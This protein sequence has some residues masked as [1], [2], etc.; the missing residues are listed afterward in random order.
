MSNPIRVCLRILAVASVLF[1]P[2]AAS[3]EPPPC[4]TWFPDFS[5]CGRSGRW[6]G[7]TMPIAAPYLFEDPFITTGVQAVGI[8]H[9][10]TD[11][12][13]GGEAWVLAVQARIAITDKLAFI[14]TKDG[15][16]WMD[17]TALGS[18]DGFWDITAGFKYA[19]IEMPEQNFILTPSLRFDIPVG[20]KKV[21]SG[22]GDGVIIPAV[23]AAWGTGKL[24]FIGDLGFRIPFSG[25]KESTSMFYNL[26]AAYNIHEHVIPLVELNGYHWISSGN[27]SSFGLGATGVEG[28]DVVNLGSTGVGGSDV[29]TMS[30]GFRFPIRKHVS[31]GMAYEIPVTQNRDIF[32]RRATLNLLIEY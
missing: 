31:A 4:P 9:D 11:S 13:L 30:F 5:D 7:F 25:N 23:S 27:D 3:A 19:L 16:T 10:F 24:H 6:E 21:L 8:W 29:L 26:S 14:A 2:V 22:N 28:V 1:A 32:E 15:Y 17:D 12:T 20:Q 18:P